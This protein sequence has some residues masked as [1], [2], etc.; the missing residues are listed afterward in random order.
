VQIGT[1]KCEGLRTERSATNAASAFAP[2]SADS[3]PKMAPAGTA[4]CDIV[5]NTSIGGRADTE[6]SPVTATGVSVCTLAIVLACTQDKLCGYC[7]HAHDEP[8]VAHEHSPDVVGKCS[9][10]LWGVRSTID[11]APKSFFSSPTR[12]R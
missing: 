12:R 7:M 10:Q 9:V 3:F 4:C 2:K 1:L 8:P 6:P 5:S 11:Q